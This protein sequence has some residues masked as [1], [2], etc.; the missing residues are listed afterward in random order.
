MFNR[1]RLLS[2]LIPFML[3]GSVY[4][5]FGQVLTFGFLEFD[6]K[7]FISENPY[8]KQGLTPESIRWAFT[9]DLTKDSSFADYWQPVTFLS[10]MLDIEWYGNNAS[11]HHLTSLILHAL[12]AILLFFFLLRA[13][14]AI[15]CSGFIAAV[16]AVHPLQAEPIAWV[17]ARKDI[18][19]TF[20][21]FGAIHF[22]LTHVKTRSLR[23]YALTA[24]C[25]ML[26]LMTKPMVIA[27]PLLLL[28]LDYWPL[29]RGAIGRS[30]I[31]A[32]IKL[33]LEKWLFILIAVL[34]VGIVFFG[35]SKELPSTILG[36]HIENIP[37]HYLH[38]LQKIFYPH[39]IAIIYPYW[40]R[41]PMWRIVIST[42]LLL[43]I[44]FWVMRLAIRRKYMLS[45][46]LWFLG[47][48]IPAM[49]MYYNNRFAYVPMIGIFIMLT[50]GLRDLF[51]DTRF[52]K[53]ILT[54]LAIFTVGTYT[55][56]ARVEAS[57]W[58]DDFS[59]FGRALEV[60]TNNYRA[61]GLYGGAL[62]RKGRGGH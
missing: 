33:I 21:S 25:F 6:D 62:F 37:S 4:C 19:S 57:Y 14:G 5:A 8:V 11:G 36:S 44:M 12:N 26:G 43:G 17:T 28:I 47:A 23:A 10:R 3:A 31:G 20:F 18:L 45:G 1:Q 55:I 13:T 50:F 61:H 32:W 53:S 29:E 39:D 30:E 40:G 59:I 49:G 27:L 41:V 52:W 2:I 48:L 9:A 54:T 34:F 38:H 15:G 24:L 35:P 22:Y 56:A 7:M 51:G 42:L 58:Q 46:W 16:F 60:T